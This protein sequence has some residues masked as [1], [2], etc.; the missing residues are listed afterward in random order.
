MKDILRIRSFMQK[1]KGDR[2]FEKK[3]FVYLYKLRAKKLA[4]IR[5]RKFEVESEQKT[6]GSKLNPFMCTGDYNQ[7]IILSTD[8]ESAREKYRALHHTKSTEVVE[9][10]NLY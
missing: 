5:T 4:E 2:D 7:V 10:I 1:N 9:V 8:E 6:T 3:M